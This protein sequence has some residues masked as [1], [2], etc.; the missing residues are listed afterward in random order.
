MNKINKT[1]YWKRLKLNN[2]QFHVE[3]HLYEIKSEIFSDYFFYKKYI[4][5]FSDSQF[6]YLTCLKSD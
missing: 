2:I 1:V 5:T 4:R 6:L 3:A